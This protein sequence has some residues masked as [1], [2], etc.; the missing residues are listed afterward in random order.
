MQDLATEIKRHGAGIA[1]NSRDR[2]RYRTV[3]AACGKNAPF[4]PHELRK[5]GL[6]YIAAGK[7]ILVTILLAR[8]RCGHCRRTFTDY[9]PFR[10]A[11]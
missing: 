1:R 2:V 7:V 4:A 5:R 11:I 3:C 8:W 9:P 10:P 6:R